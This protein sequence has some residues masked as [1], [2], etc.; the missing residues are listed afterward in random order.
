MYI[1]TS[2]GIYVMR[3]PVCLCVI[4]VIGQMHAGKVAALGVMGR[5][6]SI[7]IYL[8]SLDYTNIGMGGRCSETLAIYS[9]YFLNTRDC[10]RD[11]H[12]FII[13]S[14]QLISTEHA[15]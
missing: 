2:L 11:I 10:G 8:E 9:F 5:S 3:H 7:G 1:T 4:Q 15:F 12:W 6:T 14:T 13:L